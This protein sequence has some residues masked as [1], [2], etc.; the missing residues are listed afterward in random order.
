MRIEEAL[1]K[2]TR[3]SQKSYRY[4]QLQKICSEKRLWPIVYCEICNKMLTNP[5]SIL[6]HQGRHCQSKQ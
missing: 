5:Q 4:A 1:I 3:P 6:I 2:K